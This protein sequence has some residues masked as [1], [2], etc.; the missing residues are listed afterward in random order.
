M[1]QT[2]FIIIEGTKINLPF[3]L[4]KYAP[5]KI[6]VIFVPYAKWEQFAGPYGDFF[7]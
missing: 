4:R 5:F 7:L 1:A 3:D 2:A 6:P